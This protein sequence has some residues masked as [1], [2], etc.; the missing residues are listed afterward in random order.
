MTTQRTLW[1]AALYL[2]GCSETP[3]DGTGLDGG[4]VDMTDPLR[5][6]IPVGSVPKAVVMADVNRDGRSDLLVVRATGAG[7][8][9]LLSARTGQPRT[10][11]NALLNNNA[12]D[13][14]YGMAVADA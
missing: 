9:H 12:G 14:P 10:F 7:S 1:L 6:D 8:L 5:T 11:T 3:Q 4:V 13:T 2:L